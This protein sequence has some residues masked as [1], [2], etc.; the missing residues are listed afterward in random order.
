LR[1]NHIIGR[2]SKEISLIQAYKFTIKNQTR[3]K[4]ENVNPS[5]QTYKEVQNHSKDDDYSK[6]NDFSN[7][8]LFAFDEK[9]AIKIHRA[10]GLSST[11]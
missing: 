8:K 9:G 10:S 4:Y 5:S 2:I 1:F 6:E 11:S 7:A 3:K